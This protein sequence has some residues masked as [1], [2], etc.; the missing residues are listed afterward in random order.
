MTI[1][2]R[3]VAFIFMVI[4]CDVGLTNTLLGTGTASAECVGE[5]ESCFN[6]VWG[7][8][9]RINWLCHRDIIDIKIT[10][11]AIKLWKI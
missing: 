10:A 4:N 11:V 9:N 1:I 2:F 8:H 6:T 7:K 5:T 3:E